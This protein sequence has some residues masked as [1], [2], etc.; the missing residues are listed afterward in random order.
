MHERLTIVSVYGHSDGASAI[1]ALLN[2]LGQLAGS[3]GLLLSLRRP[4]DLPDSI[5]WREIQ[6]LN[7]LQ[8]SV[9][10][11]HCLHAFIDTDFCLVV[12][13]DGWVLDGRNFLE[14]HYEYDYIGAPCHAAIVGDHLV[15][16]FQWTRLL[17]AMVIQNGGFSLRSRRFLEAPNRHGF[18]YLPETRAPLF[19]EDIQLTGTLRP[20]LEAAGIR[21]AP[22][23]IARSFAIE[24]LGPGFHDSLDFSQLVGHHARSRRLF[25]PHHVDVG[26]SRSQALMIYREMEFL[27]HLER[28]GY[29]L[30]FRP[31]DASSP[32]VVRR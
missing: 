22:V 11:M 26:L 3:R 29:S 1:P 4:A 19:N 18:A 10:V 23:E 6:P 31:T 13:D 5:A 25:A 28:L 21:F 14:S 32:D 9:F 12:Q 8:Y 16:H 24:Y 27:E 17:N 15:Q 7:Y 2:S 20:A 30:R